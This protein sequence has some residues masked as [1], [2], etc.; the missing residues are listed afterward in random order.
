[1]GCAVNNPSLWRGK[2]NIARRYYCN[3]TAQQQRRLEA[4]NSPARRWAI[5]CKPVCGRAAHKNVLRFRIVNGDLLNSYVQAIHIYIYIYRR[6]TKSYIQSTKREN[7]ACA[8]RPSAKNITKYVVFI[9]RFTDETHHHYSEYLHI[10]AM[11]MT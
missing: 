5:K 10:K 11:I 6:L 8:L 2:V 4:V 3:S 9:I 7:R 1:M